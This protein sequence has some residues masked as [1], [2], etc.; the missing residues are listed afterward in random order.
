MNQ[1]KYCRV[2]P[3][4]ARGYSLLR[5]ILFLCKGSHGVSPIVV[6]TLVNSHEFTRLRVAKV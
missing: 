3:N 1:P 2:R 4:K 6:K 5:L